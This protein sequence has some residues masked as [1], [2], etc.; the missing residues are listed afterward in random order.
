M[1]YRDGAAT[2]P[3]RPSCSRGPARTSAPIMDFVENLGLRGDA[4][5]LLFQGRPTISYAEL[6]RRVA[7]VAVT[8]GAAKRLVAVEAE[9]S[10]HAIIAYLAALRGGHAVAL[11]P[12]GD[13]DALEEFEHAHLPDVVCRRVD[14]R[15]RMTRT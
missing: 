15:W 5:A 8:L 9:R 13:H 2:T 1:N 6:E 12:P 10:E 7:A 3:R 4:P 11:L 14:G